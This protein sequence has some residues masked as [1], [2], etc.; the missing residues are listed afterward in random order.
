[1][2]PFNEAQDGFAWGKPCD[3]SC[4]EGA[5]FDEASQNAIITGLC[6][7]LK[8]S[9]LPTKISALDGHTMLN[10]LSSYRGYSGDAADCVSQVNTHGYGGADGLSD[11]AGRANL[12]SIGKPVWMSEVGHPG[13]VGD[14]GTALK[15]SRQIVGDLQ[16]LHPEAWV[17]WQGL[18][19]PGSGH[20]GLLEAPFDGS[21]APA[22]TKRF[23][24]VGQYS[25][26][27]RPNYQILH[28]DDPGGLTVIARDPS[29]GT[30]VI[31]G[32]NHST[33]DRVVSYQ[34]SQLGQ[35][36]HDLTVYRTTATADLSIVTNP[37]K[38]DNQK[39]IDRQPPSSVTTYLLGRPIPTSAPPAA[40]AAGDPCPNA[41]SP[42]RMGCC[43][44]AGAPSERPPSA[45]APTQGG[46]ASIS[47]SGS[48][49]GS[50][51]P[52]CR[53]RITPSRLGDG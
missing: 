12:A 30:V 20:W 29:S 45:Q 51:T 11:G 34:L 36:S 16:E 48:G 15:L 47:T 38:I 26:F 50:P 14:I 39:I 31:V 40:A 44:P 43:P 22:R 46:S 4:Q 52:T 8:T 3:Q 33:K 9:G 6:A 24:V 28:A 37:P 2:E 35:V 49:A 25:E 21:T 5:N 27:I 41:S 18:E 32:A 7:A 23:S 13:A 53:A 42:P 19:E 17:Y 10:T 1:L